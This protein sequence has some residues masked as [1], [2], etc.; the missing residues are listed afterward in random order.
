MPV[1]PIRARFLYSALICA[2]AL[3]LAGWATGQARFSEET[4]TFSVAD[5]IPTATVPMH[6][7]GRSAKGATIVVELLGRLEN[8]H[9]RRESSFK[10]TAIDE[11]G[12]LIR[13]AKMVVDFGDGIVRKFSFERRIIID[14]TWRERG[15]YKVQVRLTDS[16]GATSRGKMRLRVAPPL[17]VFFQILG[18]D[19]PE[20]EEQERWR[21]VAIEREARAVMGTLTIDW[22]DGSPETVVSKFVREVSRPHTYVDEGEYTIVAFIT[23]A[24]T[25]KTRVATLSVKVTE[26]GGPIDLREAAIAINSARDIAN[27]KIT[28]TVT[29]VTI[30]G[31]QICIFHTKANQW[32]VRDGAEGNPW[33]AVFLN[34]KLH[35]GTYEWLRP[36]QVCKGITRDNIGPHVKHGP[37]AQWAPKS[38]EVVYFFVSTLAR[39]GSRTIDEMAA[40]FAKIWP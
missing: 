37:L 15:S 14:H 17:R 4:P 2:L 11:N 32:P 9:A 19:S 10:V 39:L 24:A 20:F 27:F 35:A 25:G 23:N 6:A 31:S 34:G 8:V 38:G 3:P 22:G 29:N 12:I 40:P 21:F 13:D 36:G 33:V 7:V 18:E 28:S 16:E 30:S 1:Y 26:T 5:P